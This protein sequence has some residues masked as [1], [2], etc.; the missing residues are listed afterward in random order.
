[1]TA[2]T[3]REYI[4]HAIEN[5]RA[6][7]MTLIG[8]DIPHLHQC[9]SL[10][11]QNSEEESACEI[12]CFSASLFPDNMDGMAEYRAIAS[13]LEKSRRGVR[14]RDPALTRRIR[15]HVQR[16]D[17]EHGI[18]RIRLLLALLDTLARS[19]ETALI[20]S[21]PLR[22]DTALKR[23]ETVVPSAAISGN[24]SAKTSACK[25][26]PAKRA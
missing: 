26:L 10:T 9:D 22:N 20:A 2:G 7:D 8:L 12:L 6:G 19:Q 25:P 23:Q 4:G 24:T 3:G 18:G 1:M 14:Y 13:V 11:G 5:S 16:L 21:G 15:K 17:K